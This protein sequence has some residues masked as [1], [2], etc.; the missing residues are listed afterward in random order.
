[1]GVL[2][3]LYSGSFEHFATQFPIVLQRS[4]E[5]KSYVTHKTYE[6]TAMMKFWKHTHLPIERNVKV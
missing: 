5:V 2:E 3:K 6:R 1:V 4:T